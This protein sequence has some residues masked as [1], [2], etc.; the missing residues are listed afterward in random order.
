LTHHA[1]AVSV[2][3]DPLIR[4]QNVAIIC[5]IS[6]DPRKK[7]AWGFLSMQHQNSFAMQLTPNYFLGKL[8]L[9]RMCRHIEEYNWHLT[10]VKT[11]GGE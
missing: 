9:E 1:K 7:M 2:S 6:I 4:L 3:N 11:L 10:K 8:I 5:Q